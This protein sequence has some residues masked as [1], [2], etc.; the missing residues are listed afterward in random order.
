MIIIKTYVVTDFFN[1]DSSNYQNQRNLSE[2]AKFVIVI[3]ETLAETFAET[4]AEA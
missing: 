1:F 4:F 2:L 3:I